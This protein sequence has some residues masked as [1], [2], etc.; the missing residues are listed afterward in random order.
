MPTTTYKGELY[1]K[2]VYYRD[3]GFYNGIWLFKEDG[4]L[5]KTRQSEFNKMLNEFPNSKEGALWGHVFGL[6]PSIKVPINDIPN[7]KYNG[8]HSGEEA[9]KKALA[10]CP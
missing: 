3:Q 5:W 4:D 1:G 10:R 2:K 9:L 7:I 6:Y 8:Q